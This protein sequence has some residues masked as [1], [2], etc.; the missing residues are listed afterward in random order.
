MDTSIAELVTN[1]ESLQRQRNQE[2]QRIRLLNNLKLQLQLMDLVLETKRW[3]LHSKRLKVQGWRGSSR[4][5]R[6][7]SHRVRFV[8]GKVMW[9]L[10]DRVCL[11]P[12]RNRWWY[13]V[14]HSWRWCW[15]DWQRRVRW[16]PS[17]RRRGHWQS[18]VSIRAD[19]CLEGYILDD[20]DYYDLVVGK[21]KKWIS[22]G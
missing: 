4:G 12:K 7:G 1:V 19:V 14:Q 15:L 11:R 9:R 16:Y 20:L 5:S 2:V 6:C 17:A 10:V 3:V 18:E 8:L 22:E 13:W 21:K